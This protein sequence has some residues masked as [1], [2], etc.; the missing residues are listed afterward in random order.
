MKGGGGL[1]LLLLIVLIGGIALA[2][3]G[4]LTPTR[5]AYVQE[6]ILGII[7]GGIADTDEQ[8]YVDSCVRTSDD[9]P[10]KAVLR[11]RRIVKFRD[12]TQLEIIFSGPPSDNANVQC[13]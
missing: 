13:P 12:G 10:P 1:I 9:A 7:H 3:T 4:V 5:L 8:S 11:Q 6:Q 2:G